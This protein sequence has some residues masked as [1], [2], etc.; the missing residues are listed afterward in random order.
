MKLR[1]HEAKEVARKLKAQ[2]KAQRR[3]EKATIGTGSA[4]K[5][6]SSNDQNR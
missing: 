1:G 5:E 4:K 2:R 3:K 6:E